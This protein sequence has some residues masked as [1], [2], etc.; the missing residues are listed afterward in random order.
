MIIRLSNMLYIRVNKQFCAQIH[1]LQEVKMHYALK[2]NVY[3]VKGY[4][5][6]CLYDFNLSKL[7]WLDQD[8]ADFIERINNGEIFINKLT[9]QQLNI[10]K[11]LVQ[12]S[13]LRETESPR[14]NSIEEIK[15]TDCTIDFAWIEITQKC[16][17]KCIHCY[18]ESAPQCDKDM[19]IDKYKM[20]I[21][22]LI[23]RNIK[24]IQ[25]IGG[26]PFCHPDLK[27]IL[28][29]TVGKFDFIEIFTNGTLITSAWLDYFIAHNIRIALSVYS[30][31][32]SMHDRVTGQVKSWEKT[33]SIIKMLSQNAIPYRVCNIIMK[34]IE[35]G[36]R[37]NQPYKLSRTKDIVR[38]SG[39]ANF[40][41]LDNDLIRRKLITKETFGEPIALNFS[42]RIISG[43]NCFKNKIYI[44]SDM[45]VFP[46]V[47]ERRLKHCRFDIHKGI[48]IDEEI[49]NLTKDHIEECKDCEFRY[50]CFD[51][52]PNSLSEDVLAK[53]WYCTYD[54]R[55]AVWTDVDAFVQKLND[56]W[57][58]SD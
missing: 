40:S 4:I 6:G 32:A 33:N 3:L 7:Y 14:K 37:T 28:D 44:S 43:H 45:D 29:Y 1:L 58:T 21:D 50:A 5:N 42:R 18:N 25:L 22:S 54:P 47:M 19:E 39:R 24:R 56:E 27:E 36:K 46:C 10:C 53:P 9:P 48:Q 26:E 12:E 41:L 55:S 17:L 49:A 11:H 35:I 52:R 15:H 13:L 8:L 31:D 2:E 20:I 16:N 51:C 23:S 57:K 38:M 34:D 30:Y